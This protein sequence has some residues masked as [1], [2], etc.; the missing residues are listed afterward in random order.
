MA[1]MRSAPKP[2]TRRIDHE[3][4]GQSLVE[5][6]RGDATE[7]FQ[8]RRLAL[9]VMRVMQQAAGRLDDVAATS[10]DRLRVACAAGCSAC[11]RLA[12]SVLSIEALWIAE[13][14]R[15]SLDGAELA[16]QA[17]R[18]RSV[19][20]QVSHLTLEARAAV[21]VAC[22]LL[23]EAGACSIHA[24][25]PLGCR[26]W[27]S[28]SRSDCERALDLAEPG[29]CGPMDHA[30]WLAAG[31]T[32]EG[33]ERA[34][35]ELGLEAGPFELHAALCVALETPDAGARWLAGEA[36]FAGCP[37]VTSERLRRPGATESPPL[38]HGQTVGPGGLAD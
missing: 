6:T 11:C 23:G 2:S 37:R 12:V 13:R 35:T 17:A 20:R 30:M 4:L 36:I 32:T 24:F 27:T 3:D 34:L 26:G 21:R 8:D 14:L 19:S 16:M 38:V 29:H 28:F 33:L 7:L 5:A 1:R 9:P 18:V 15:A 22:A 25:R 10:P 31:C